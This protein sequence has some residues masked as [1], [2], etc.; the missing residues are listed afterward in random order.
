[1][2]QPSKTKA[3]F[4]HGFF[5]ARP[6]KLEEVVYNWPCSIEFKSPIPFSHQPV[7]AIPESLTYLIKF[8]KDGGT[9]TD[10]IKENGFEKFVI[11]IYTNNDD[12]YTLD[13]NAEGKQVGIDD[14]HHIFD[15]YL[16]YLILG[17]TIDHLEI[18]NPSGRDGQKKYVLDKLE[19]HDH[20]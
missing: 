18:V 12:E 16:I 6:S 1:M 15:S 7:T 20:Q 10:S 2:H 17:S 19:I 13:P 9:Q 5:S 4:W 11:K 14:E 3:S 8:N